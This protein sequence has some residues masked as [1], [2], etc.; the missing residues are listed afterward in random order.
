MGFATSLE[1]GYPVSVAGGFVFEPQ[2]QVVYQTTNLDDSGDTA[3]TVQ[4]HDVDSL[5]ARIGARLAHSWMLDDGVPSRR[6]TAW[7]RPSYWDE[8]RGQP[9]TLFSSAAGPVP[10][11]SEIDGGWV[12][13]DTGLSAAIGR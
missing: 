9:Q 8:F 1:T 6:I 11:S 10:F 3:A 2:A 4:F 12:E 13:V 7:I 5:A